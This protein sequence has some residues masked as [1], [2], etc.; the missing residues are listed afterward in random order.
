MK[1]LTDGTYSLEV[2]N[3]LLQ[4]T[5]K[6][7]ETFVSE[8]E[9]KTALKGYKLDEF[10]AVLADLSIKLYDPKFTEDNIWRKERTGFIVHKL[11]Q[12][13]VT[14]F[15]IEYIADIVLISGSNNFKKESIK[16][17]D[18]II[19]LFNIYNNL[20]LEPINQITSA[21]SLLVPIY[22]QQIPSQRDIKDTLVRQWL[23]FQTSQE[24]VDEKS[25]LDLDAILLEKSGMTVMEYVKLCFLILAV[26]IENPRF[27]FGTFA[28]SS[29]SGM[30][31]VL[32]NAKISAIL[33]QLSITPIKFTELDEKFNVKLKPEYTRSKYNP[34]WE[35]PI[36]ILG[37]NDY[38]VPSISAYVKGALNGLYWIFENAKGKTFRD[39]FGKVFEKYCGLII[40]DI[41]G[42]KNVRPEI[43]FGNKDQH[44]F[45]WIVNSNDE[46]LLFETKG[47]Q[48][49][50]DTLQ[51]G[52]EEC[53]NKAVSQDLVET[54]KQMYLRCQDISKYKELELFRDKKKTAIGVFYDIPLVSTNMYDTYIQFALNELDLKYP[55][56]KDFKYIFLSIE[57]LENYYC[58]KNYI[59]INALVDRVKNTPG[60]GILSEVD[61]ISKENDQSTEKCKSL[62]N[63]K[64]KDFYNNELGIVYPGTG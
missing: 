62:L 4:L 22:Y 54:I 47:Y 21:Q 46:I 36:I 48:F 13:W 35:K 39:Y 28:K 25:K 37:E 64:F 34:L 14:N 55:G 57:E 50:L 43:K 49:S 3:R 8:E 29:I 45:D 44:F 52:D 20:I 2:D 15:S 38:I 12:Q 16:N 17:K 60:A 6:G 11:S 32:N 30:N 1:L 26:I 7:K 18:N 59:S 23:I 42:E 19:D 51:T 58:V 33:K 56:I 53:I 41:F 9:F 40:N 5:K 10:L 27:N 61:K 31:D 24:L 63:R